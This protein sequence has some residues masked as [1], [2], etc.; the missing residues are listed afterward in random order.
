MYRN[1]VSDAIDLILGANVAEQI[2]LTK[3]S[4]KTMA[5]ISPV[6]FLAG[7]F[8]ENNQIK[9]EISPISRSASTIPSI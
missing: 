4:R 8:R 9:L 5:S 6:Q 2:F 7:L 1:D 3:N